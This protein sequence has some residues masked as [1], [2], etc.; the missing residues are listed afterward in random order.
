VIGDSVGAEIRFQKQAARFIRKYYDDE[1]MYTTNLEKLKT[2][3]PNYDRVWRDVEEAE[4][5]IAFHGMQ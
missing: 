5:V 3:A 1:P 4:K 2:I